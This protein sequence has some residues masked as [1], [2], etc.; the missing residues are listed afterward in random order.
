M[1]EYTEG[2][3]LGLVWGGG[4]SRER[5]GK[6]S[7]L[8]QTRKTDHQEKPDPDLKPTL[9]KQPEFGSSLLN[10]SNVFLSIFK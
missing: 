5:E 4:D 3:G 7:G 9:E 2:R 6:G 10:S 1:D 8:E